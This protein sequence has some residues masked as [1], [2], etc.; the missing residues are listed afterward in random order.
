LKGE[1]D[2]HRFAANHCKFYA[3]DHGHVHL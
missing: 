1:L 3:E 2:L